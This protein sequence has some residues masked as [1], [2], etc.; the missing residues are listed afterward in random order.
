MKILRKVDMLEKDQVGT[1]VKIQ[2]ANMDWNKLFS[3]AQI[4]HVTWQ[5]YH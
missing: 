4:V 1:V 5:S 2:Y 3:R